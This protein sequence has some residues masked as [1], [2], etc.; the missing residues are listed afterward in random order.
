MELATLIDAADHIKRLKMYPYFDVAHYIL[1]CMAVREDNFPQQI[2]GVQTFSRLHP[3]ACWFGS[4]M[5][6]FAGG[7]L[8]N[9][10]LGEP[11]LTP[12]NN[13]WAVLTATVV[14][15]CINYAPF[16]FVYKL[17]KFGPIKAVISL[18]K[19]VRRA[20][21]VHYGILFALKN[22]PGSHVIVAI[23]GILKGSASQHMRIFQRL[24]CG[25][26]QPTGIELLKPS[27]VTKASTVAAI[28]FI[29]SYE[30]YI[31][32]PLELVYLA[33]TVFF[34]FV[35]LLTILFSVDVFAPFE[36]L[37]CSIFMGG[38]MDALKRATERPDDVSA[39]TAKNSP[40]NKPKEE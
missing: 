23:F 5:L 24:V 4:M 9:F 7:I 31:E 21:S 19:E 29:L 3:L 8:G 33:V 10:L 35:R 13:E 40:G 2:T 14:W 26:W 11:L 36:N 25:I 32:L 15:Y 34:A 28:A 16:D 22:F 12:L 1:M 20:N 37:F 6:C 38:V 39:T 30:G 17:C 18:M 27:V